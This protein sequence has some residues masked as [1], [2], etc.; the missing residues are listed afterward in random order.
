[1]LLDESARWY[2]YWTVDALQGS[3]VKKYYNE[4][5]ESF[6]HSTKERVL[7]DKIQKLI[8]HA[9]KTT[10]FYADFDED[11]PL[12]DLPIVTKDQIRANYDLFTSSAYKGAPDNRTMY[13]SGSTGTPFMVVQNKDKIRHNT[14]S[15]IL[16]S[17][18]AGYFIGMKVAFIR[19]WVGDHAKRSRLSL[20]AENMIQIDWANIDDAALQEMVEGFRKEKV[21]V[22][23]G[24]SSA[25]ARISRFIDEHNIDTSDFSIRCVIPMSESM[26]VPVRRNIERQFKCP[27]RA[28]YSN[29]ENGIMGIQMPHGD[30][31]YIDTESY[32][33]EILKMDSDEPAEDG[34]LGR[35]VITDLY[36][37]AMPLIRYENGDLAAGE[38]K[39]SH[40]RY[41]FM[42]TELYG[43]RSDLIYDTKGRI[44]SPFV[45]YNGLAMMD[46]LKQYRFIQEDVKRY[47]LELN[48]DA[49]KLDT[50]AMKE[51]VRRYFG[52]DAEVD[53]QFVGEIPVLNSGK[54]KNIVNRCPAYQPR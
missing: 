39:R 30:G 29:E 34:E 45:L 4:I 31:Y 41:R 43:R 36:N 33:Y 21:Q 2:G 6:R 38:H 14:A 22:L 47:T 50:E 15:S 12:T 53:V 7:D 10:P 52:D 8:A 40:G 20:I 25:L 18:V 27:V 37:Y 3:H 28:W 24:Y 26:P 51:L 35:I 32:Y 54:M 1:M 17:A 16:L 49:D 46:D 13:T 5:R 9:V 42:L 48:G 44:V 19:L 11:T 23:I